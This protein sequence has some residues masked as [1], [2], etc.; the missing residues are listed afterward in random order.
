[1][2]AGDDHAFPR[3]VDTCVRASDAIRRLGGDGRPYTHIELPGS[4]REAGGEFVQGVYHWIVDE[5]GMIT[6]RQFER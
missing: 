1:M 5:A 6:H 3:L 2:E 4:Y